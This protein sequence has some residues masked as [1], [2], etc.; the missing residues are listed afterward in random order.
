MAN[1]SSG[2]LAGINETAAMAPGI[3]HRVLRLLGDLVDADLV[4]RLAR[5]LD[6]DLGVDG[7]LA[8]LVERQRIRERLGD[9]LNGEFDSCVTAFVDVP[10]RRGQ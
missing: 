3:D 8:D 6:A 5:G 1:R 10:V 4:E 7:I 9:R 2:V